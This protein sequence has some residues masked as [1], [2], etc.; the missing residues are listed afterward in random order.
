MERCA[1]ILT[2][3][4]LLA[5]VAGFFALNN[6]SQE[7]AHLLGATDDELARIITEHAEAKRMPDEVTQQRIDTLANERHDKYTLLTNEFH[8]LNKYFEVAIIGSFTCLAISIGFSVLRR[9]VAK[10]TLKV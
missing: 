9:G 8:R 3:L 5:S 1:A 10:R 6:V 2:V 4:F 7:R